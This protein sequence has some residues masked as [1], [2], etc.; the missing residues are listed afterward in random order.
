MRILRGVALDTNA[1]SY[2]DRFQ[3]IAELESQ[4]KI[5]KMERDMPKF[6]R[7]QRNYIK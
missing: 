5:R 2:V 3:Q 4:M 7:A 6:L 1:Y